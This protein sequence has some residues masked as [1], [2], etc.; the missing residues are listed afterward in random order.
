MTLVNVW[1][2]IMSTQLIKRQ[3]SS[4]YSPGSFFS[5]WPRIAKKKLYL[6]V[7]VGC[8]EGVWEGVWG[9]SGGAD[10]ILVWCNVLY[11]RDTTQ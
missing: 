5:Q 4:F 6:E 2:I 10:I 11:I 3:S 7:S 8:R 9:L 1:G